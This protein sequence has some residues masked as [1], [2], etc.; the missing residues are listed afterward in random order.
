MLKFLA[1]LDEPLL[2]FAP[3]A[4]FI[5]FVKRRHLLRDIAFG[6]ALIAA[7]LSVA[8]SQQQPVI[9][10][11]VKLVSAPTLVFSNT[12]RL[13]PG[14]E[15]RD[16]RVFDDDR[17]QKINLDAVAAPPVV[18]VAVQTN[19]QVRDYLPFIAKVGSV[20]D[21]LLLGENGKAAVLSYGDDVNV[22]TPFETEDVQSAFKKL[23][24]SGRQS[25]MLDAGMR[26]IEL[27]KAQPIEG[28]RVLL[29]I[30]QP[31][32]QGSA[33]PLETLRLQAQSAN[34]VIYS[35]ALPI[36]G[37]KFVSDTFSFPSMTEQRGGVEVG[38]E[39]TSL[40]P[41]LRRGAKSRL[42][43]D[44]FSQ[45]TAATGGTQTHFRKQAQLE[46]GAIAI[47]EE[48]R[49]TYLISYSPDSPQPGYHTIRVEVDIPGARTYTRPGYVRTAD[50]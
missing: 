29:F 7:A 31:F 35:L 9:R 43:Q 20:I 49:S 8:G 19:Q 11:P 38:A 28:T 12:G 32:D 10:V 18:V 1:R 26:A 39:L 21:T 16:F 22:V 27:L 24:P 42:G 4:Y 44:P 30:G 47:G 13:I 17:L 48:L 23:S 15:A 14:L 3:S 2:M 46:N 36:A 41:A 25:H 40:I 50:E 33:T 6:A 37:K 5:N 45:L 34:V